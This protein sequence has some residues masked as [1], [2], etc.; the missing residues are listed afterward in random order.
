MCTSTDLCVKWLTAILSQL[1]PTVRPAANFDPA[2]DAQALRKAMKGFGMQPWK[3][4]PVSLAVKS[5]RDNVTFCYCLQER[6]KMQSLTLLR[7]EAML[8]GR[9]LDRPLNLSW[10][11][12]EEFIKICITMSLYGCC[13]L[14]NNTA[15]E[16]I[17]LRTW[18]RTWSLNCQRTWRG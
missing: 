12:W 16:S 4:R 17:V 14:N 7:R 18:W 11:G 3:P 5:Q 13:C 10:D 2:A 1:Q 9:R 15:Q 6:T 8:R